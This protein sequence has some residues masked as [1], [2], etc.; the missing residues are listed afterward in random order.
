MVTIEDVVKMMNDGEV[1]PEKVLRLLVRGGVG[2]SLRWEPS[3]R[4]WEYSNGRNGGSSETLKQA[5]AWLATN[6]VQA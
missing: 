5:V 6:A 2:V 3:R 1:S 4:C